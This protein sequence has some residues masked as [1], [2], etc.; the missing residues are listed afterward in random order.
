[1]MIFID[2]GTFKMGS[3]AGMADERPV[4]TVTLTNF[5]MDNYETT[6]E[7][8]ENIVGKNPSYFSGNSA[9][10]ENQSRRPVERIS[11]YDAFVYCNKRSLKE[12]LT[13]FYVLN[14]SDNCN[15]WGP[16]PDNPDSRWN[17]VICRWQADGYRLPTE[18]EWEY[19]AR[20][21]QNCAS[22]HPS[23]HIPDD[24]TWNKNNS[25]MITHAV[26]LKKPNPLGLYDMFGNIWEWCWDRYTCYIDG[27]TKNPHSIDKAELTADRIVRGGAWNAEPS[28]CSPYFRNGGSPAARYSFIGL[29]VV[30]SSQ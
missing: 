23:A 10:G 18:A 22:V 5:L 16:V 29:R 13:P 30:R 8:W 9:P 11:Q 7:D 20:G 21:G 1:M 6:Q 27:T 3:P 19:A 14:N 17:A 25:N 24:D 28:D 2:G 4:H 26:G 12:G 15:D